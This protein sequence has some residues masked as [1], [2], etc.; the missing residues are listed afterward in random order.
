M[1][2]ARRQVILPLGGQLFRGVLP[3]QLVDRIAV[4]LGVILQ[5]RCADQRVQL[6]QRCPGHR[7]HRAPSAAPAK[8]R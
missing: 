8:N 4:A 1:P 6:H 5:Q 7:L 3:Q 2:V